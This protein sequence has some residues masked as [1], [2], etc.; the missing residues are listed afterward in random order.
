MDYSVTSVESN[1]IPHSLSSAE[2]SSK[3]SSSATSRAFEAVQ[4]TD[5]RRS[6]RSWMTSWARR[7]E[8]R[9]IVTWYINGM[10]YRLNKGI[11]LQFKI[12]A[13]KKA[14]KRHKRIDKAHF[15]K[16]LKVSGAEIN[17]NKRKHQIGVQNSTRRHEKYQENIKRNTKTQKANTS[18]NAEKSGFG[19]RNSQKCHKVK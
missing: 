2:S 15:W 3:I 11:L 16:F 18:T 12:K 1:T 9:E 17:S 14:P 8:S 10:G 6:R 5:E 13:N 7:A 19:C 4:T